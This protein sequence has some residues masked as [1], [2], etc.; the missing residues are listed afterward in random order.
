MH[1]ARILYGNRKRIQTKK[2]RLPKSTFAMI[3]LRRQR[4]AL[5]ASRQSTARQELATRLQHLTRP[6]NGPS[7]YNGSKRTIHALPFGAPCTRQREESHD[8]TYRHRLRTGRL[9]PRR[10]RAAPDS[11]L[12][13]HHLE[14]RHERAHGRACSTWKSPAI[15]TRASQNPTN[16]AVAAK[17]AE[18]EGGTGGH[19]ARR[20]GQ[21]ANFFA[22]F[23]I[24]GAGD[25]VVASSAIYGGTYNLLAHTMRRMG[26]ECTFVAPDCTDE[27]LEAA[28][29]PNTKAV[30][31]ETIAN[32]ALAVLDIERFAAAAHA[33]GVPLI[34]DNTFPTPVQLPP[35]RV[36]RRHRDA[37]HHQVHGRPRRQRGRL[38]SWTR[39]NFDWMAHAEQFPGL[40]HPGRELSRRRPTPSASAGQAPSSPRRRPSSCGTSAAMQ[41]PAERLLAEPGAGEPAR[42]HGAALRERPGRGASSCQSHPKVAWVRYPRP[43]RRHVAT[44]WRRSTCR[45]AAAAW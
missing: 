33:H 21:A 36:G 13:V 3:R 16:D 27:E 12:P 2:R 24:A 4:P 22:V 35:H 38:P 19:A 14:V 30:F 32:P 29:R 39:G 10:R 7:P 25:H 15:S 43:A 28:F 42:A 8:R 40:T 31:G 26:L 23:N 45:T 17:I 37:L 6:K 20:S 9:P 5:V 18:L 1:C 11:H 34:V 44:R 41:S